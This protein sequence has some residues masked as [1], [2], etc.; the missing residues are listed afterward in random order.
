M[1]SKKVMLGDDFGNIFQQKT[2]E[3][4]QTLYDLKV[5]AKEM[6]SEGEYPWVL[7]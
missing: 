5:Y 4:I 7:L 1:F 6:V 3:N 2:F